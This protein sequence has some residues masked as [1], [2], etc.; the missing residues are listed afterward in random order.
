MTLRST[1]A[2]RAFAYAKVNLTLA[3][4]GRRAD[5]FHALESVF[6]L[7][8]LADEVSVRVS[9]ASPTSDAEADE[10]ALEGSRASDL[11]GLRPAENL[12]LRALRLLRREVG[13]PLPR[14][15]L[16]LRKE[17]P[18]AAGLGGGS[19]DAAAALTTAA[20]AWDVALSPRARSRLGEELGSD[21]PFFL[22]RSP[23][24]LVCGRGEDVAPLPPP[25]GELGLLLVTPRERLTTASVFAAHDSLIASGEAGVTGAGT[26]TRRLASALEAGIAAGAVVEMAGELRNANDLW[27]PAALL[28]PSLAA[29]REALEERLELPLLLSGS[30]PTLVGL[31]PS[32]NEARAAAEALH[33]PEPLPDGATV[34]T[35]A[36]ETGRGLAA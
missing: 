26:V 8:A 22:A 15:H 13:R 19:S 30:G 12:A 11:A 4:T 36:A 21:V 35:T 33:D 16:T 34:I 9:H 10:L 17:I 14:A 5:G 7:I 32:A 3:V 1:A 27:P 28:S 24:A 23:A 20:E 6:L 25:R 2:S 18:V 29:L 31:Y